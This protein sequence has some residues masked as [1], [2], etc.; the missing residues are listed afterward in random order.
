VQNSTT[1]RLVPIDWG[2]GHGY[3]GFYRYLGLPCLDLLVQ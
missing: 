1:Q 2:Y 3:K